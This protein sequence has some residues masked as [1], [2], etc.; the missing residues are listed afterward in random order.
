M[1][2]GDHVTQRHRGG[3][4]LLD[5]TSLI[6]AEEYIV[7]QNHRSRPQDPFARQC[8]VEVVQSLIFV[9]EVH[10]VH[11]TLPSPTP[12]DFGERP[13]LLRELIQADLVRPLALPADRWA[14]ATAAQAKALDD[15]TTALGTTSVIQFVDQAIVCDGARPGR[16]SLSARLI[17]WSRFQQATVRVSGHHNVRIDSHDG[18]EPD[19]FGEWARSA[20]V[21]LHRAL[22]P[23]APPGEG[24][25]LMATLARG[26]K[27]QARADAAGLCYQPHP[28]RR[29]FLLTFDLNQQ[30]AEDSLVLEVIKT[31]RGIPGSIAE[32]S[33]QTEAL[34]VRLLE[35]EL[36][37][38]G[39]RLWS[40]GETGKLADLAW[41]HRVVDRIKQY[42][43]EASDLRAAIATCVT[44]EDYLRLARDIEGV[45]TRLLETLGL[46]RAEPSPLE[47]DLVEGVAS[48]A[49]T[50]TGLPIV[51]G[52]YFGSRGIGRG[53]VRRLRSRPFQQFLYR[54]FIR[55]WRLT[56]P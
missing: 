23:V 3:S 2:P 1:V 11:P 13:H 33:G 12:D 47:R 52:L 41:I 46:R 43:A 50:A 18:I 6:G 9:P 51:S 34:R 21:V 25:Y 4:V 55:A 37:L 24:K 32:A 39:G 7:S 44:D 16:D 48:V 17:D 45:R 49:Q 5:V 29:D 8:F 22:A 14:S 19:E 31:I 35:F 28:M 38:I 40:D 30:G 56:R 15:L 20:A 26:L 54:E 42:R 10:V 36:P 27:Y 53:V